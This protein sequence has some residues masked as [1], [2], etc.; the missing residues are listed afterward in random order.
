[1]IY[2]C[3][4]ALIDMIPRLIEPEVTAFVPHNGGAV[5]NTAVALGRLEVPT[6]MITG[7]SSDQFGR[8][9]Q[10]G[11][12]ASHVDTAMVQIRANPT[13]LAVVGL[14]DGQAVYS[15]YDEN[16]AGR[17]FR[18]ESAPDLPQPVECLFFGG[19]SLCNPPA[20]DSYLRLA[21]DRAGGA[22]VML[23]PNIRPGFIEDEAG[24][25]ARLDRMISLATIVKVSDEDLDW[26][27]G[28]AGTPEDKIAGI[29]NRGPSVAILTRGSRGADAFLAGGRQVS[30][31]AA[32]VCPVDTVG[33]GDTFN[34]GFLARAQQLGILTPDR[35]AGIDEADLRDCLKYAAAAAAVAVS[36]AGAN[37][38]WL[39]ELDI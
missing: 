29:L 33:A 37:P 28:T 6:G 21:E 26:L 1:M 17:Q 10:D 35:L 23:D 39:H 34:A 38:P 27:F 15:F 25:R 31:P 9:L 4:E 11:L 19:I 2:C 18:F 30:V 24:Y 36:R 12:H 22:V 7:L 14:R 16:S 3:G 20:A 32:Q 5:Y 13:T 8:Q